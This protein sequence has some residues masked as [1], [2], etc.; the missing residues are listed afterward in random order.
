MAVDSWPA[1][2]L[3]GFPPRVLSARD[4]SDESLL[5]SRLVVISG[6]WAPT[7]VPEAAI[8]PWST[9]E[10]RS[11]SWLPRADTSVPKAFMI[12]TS[13]RARAVLLIRELA[14]RE[15]SAPPT[16]QGPGMKLSP[17]L[18]T[19][20]LGYWSSNLS[21]RAPMIGAVLTPS[22]PLSP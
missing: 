5:K 2:L 3:A 21:I 19:K 6:N 12:A 13:G 15:G 4:T 22:S 11:N 8:A 10:P 14:L 7:Q 9:G 1:K 17:S 18:I 20:V 16:N